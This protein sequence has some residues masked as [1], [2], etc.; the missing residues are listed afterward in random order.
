MR[1]QRNGTWSGTSN[2]DSLIIGP[3]AS[4]DLTNNTLITNTPAGT[5]TDGVYTG[6]Q[7]DVQRAY[8][9]GAW[10]LPGLMT[11]EEQAGPSIALTTIAVATGEQALFLG[12]A[13]T[14]LFAGQTVSGAT[15]IAMYTYAGDVD[16]NGSVDAVDYGTIDNWIQFPGTSGYTNGDLN[17]DGVIDAVD[18]GI[19]DNTI[20]L[21]G[22]P[23]TVNPSA[24]AALTAVPEPA[25]PSLA[26]LAAAL[27]GGR[28]RRRRRRRAI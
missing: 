26:M 4:L 28:R 11:S 17:Y 20:Q 14:G 7:G 5:A 24:P 12:L 15:T 13:E 21:Q 9:F 23:L 1:V 27:L 25:A 19:I 6:V 8:N 3:G 18:Y 2:V 16:L 10:D 22:P